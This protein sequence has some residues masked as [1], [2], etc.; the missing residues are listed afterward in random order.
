[1]SRRISTSKRFP[2]RDT[3]YDNL[4]VS[5]LINRILKSGKMR[6]TGPVG[7]PLGHHCVPFENMN[8]FPG[9]LEP[10]KR[11]PPI[12][13]ICEKKTTS[14]FHCSYCQYNL[15]KMCS[16]VYCTFG[17][18]MKI[19]TAGESDC[20]CVVCHTHPVYS[21]YRCTTCH[22]YD[23]C[24]FVHIRKVVQLLRPLLW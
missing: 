9:E 24:D 7:C 20:S 19:W 4:L 10:S 18:E 1:M 14:G 12:C 11:I 13:N 17:H 5:L 6:A 16:T 3:K 2:E 22:D 23:I 8:E 15:C 21:G